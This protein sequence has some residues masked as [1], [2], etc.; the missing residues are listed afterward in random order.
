[1][2]ETDPTRIDDPPKASSDWLLIVKDVFPQWRDRLESSWDAADEVYYLLR[3]SETVSA[4]CRVDASG[5]EIPDTAKFLYAED[6]QDRRDNLLLEPDPDGGARTL[7]ILDDEYIHPGDKLPG[8]RTEFYVQRLDRD[9]WERRYPT[10]AAP[11]P[12]PSK[13]PILAPAPSEELNNKPRQKPGPKPDLEWWEKIET[14]CYELMDHNGDFTPDD[15]E[16]DCQARL[17]KALM[18]FCQPFGREPGGSTLREKLPGWLS[19]WHK[20][21]TGKA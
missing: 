3:D 2:A 14:K 16:W 21:K 5:K 15:P 1:M 6:W 9:R 10:L 11:P 20:R 8:E 7:K 4:K 13:E 19:A 18:D 17:E 12:A